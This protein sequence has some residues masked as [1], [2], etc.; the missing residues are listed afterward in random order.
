M[1]GALLAFGLVILI[2]GIRNMTGI[3]LVVSGM[4]INILF[5]A[6]AT[7]LITL[8]SQFAQNIFMW[9]AGNLAQDGWQKWL[10]YY[11]YCSL[12]LLLSVSPHV[13]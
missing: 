5:G 3:P 13:L 11:L 9:G 4:V 10:V 2:A 6:I 7:A 8:N 1:V 12:L